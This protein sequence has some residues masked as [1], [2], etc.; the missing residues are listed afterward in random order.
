[1]TRLLPILFLLTLPSSAATL[2]HTFSEAYRRPALDVATS[3]EQLWIADGYGVTVASRGTPPIP[4]DSLTLPGSTT[5]LAPDGSD[6]WIA[7]DRTLYRARW[8]GRQVVIL[9]TVDAG[10]P[11]YDLT[12]VRNHLFLATPSGLVR[13]DP[14]VPGSRNILPTTSGAAVSLASDGNTLVVADG[15]DTV[16]IFSVEIPALTQKIGVA[17]LS[18]LGANRVHVVHG[19]LLVSN[20]RDSQIF[21]GLRPPFQSLGVLRVGAL[22]ASTTTPGL[23][24]TAGQDT[25]VRMVDLRFSAG[26]PAV[27]FEERLSPSSG[28]LNR[29]FRI[30]ADQNSVYLAAGDLGLLSYDLVG[31]GSPFPLVRSFV[32]GANRVEDLG[33]GQVV[34]TGGGEPPRLYT[35]ESSGSLREVT[36][37]S[38][39]AGVSVLEHVAEVAVV[40]EAGTVR[41]VRP[42]GSVTGQFQFGAAVTSAA[43]LDGT[44]WVT[45]GDRTL[46]KVNAAGGTPEKVD[47][48]GANPSFIERGAGRLILGSLND[49]GTTTI[50]EVDRV[51]PSQSRSV[52]VQGLAT[53]GAAVG[54]STVA[55]ASFRGLSLLDLGT[56]TEKLVP[57]GEGV[58]PR[59]LVAAG[60]EIVVLA[61]DRVQ[62]R[63]IDNGTLVEELDLLSEG[64]A[65][66]ADSGA[67]VLVAATDAIYTLQSGGASTQ[68]RLHEAINPASFYEELE[69][70]NDRI[71]LVE[72]DR[73][74][75]RVVQNRGL[76]AFE[77]ETEI[78]GDLVDL[79]ATDVGFCGLDSRGEVSCFDSAGRVAGIGSIPALDD[80]TFLSIHWSRGSLFVSLLE[81]C[82]G[83]GCRKRTAV[84]RLSGS[85]VAVQ[86]EIP[87]EIVTLAD[88]GDRIVMITDFPDEVRLYRATSSIPELVTARPRLTELY[89]VAIRGEIVYMVGETVV[90]LSA[91]SLAELGTVLGAFTPGSGTSAQDQRIA[92]VGDRVV[93]SGR[94]PGLAV[95]SVQSPTSWVL[96]ESFVFAGPVR[97]MV[98]GPGGLVLRTDYS[99]E[100]LSTEPA[101]ARRR[102]IH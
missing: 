67:R 17:T 42:S 100:L 25:T 96:E 62:R 34:A 14:A 101:P 37:W 90:A 52:R 22:S 35:V 24:L 26:R 30:R 72:G 21:D 51:S 47:I 60:S 82:L 68:P 36:R 50:H 102:T 19:D 23:V 44:I 92:L 86:G 10:E 48:P 58:V 28:T 56:G 5:L 98:E 31:F 78:A 8:D 85:Q 27:V 99:L 70:R 73:V 71:H 61:A 9:S 16:D 84:A 40:A 91:P 54:E 6:M 80:A 15:D 55:M 20:G 49:D 7:S 57:M 97:E 79:A 45:L 33:N 32:S 93:L 77:I 39:L 43:V 38:D 69:G 13:I 59:D 53:S 89:D 64:L 65:L 94:P 75:S 12:V 95:Y 41:L 83:E 76:A 63:R 18:I 3:G 74:V 66:G 4:L 2:H 46:W 11:V 29:I 88:S 1:M 87:G 81:G